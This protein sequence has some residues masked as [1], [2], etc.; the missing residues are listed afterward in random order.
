MALFTDIFVTDIFVSNI[1]LPRFAY[2]NRSQIFR[3]HEFFSG[4]VKRENL[5]YLSNKS[6]AYS[7]WMFGFLRAKRLTIFGVLKENHSVF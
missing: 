1:L 4:I 7:P 6:Q 2:F 5:A 3:R